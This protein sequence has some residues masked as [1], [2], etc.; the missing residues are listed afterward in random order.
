[1]RWRE[2]DTRKYVRVLKCAWADSVPRARNIA[3]TQ[4]KQEKKK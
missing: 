1:M 3:A 2:F 4:Q